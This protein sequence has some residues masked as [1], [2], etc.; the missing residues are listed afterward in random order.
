M[1][2]VRLMF[3]YNLGVCDGKPLFFSRKYGIISVTVTEAVVRYVE[4]SCDIGLLEHV[5]E[6]CIAVAKCLAFSDSMTTG[7]RVITHL[8]ENLSLSF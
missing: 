6:Y 4:L 3:L 2:Q 8:F 1:K 7:Y 5:N